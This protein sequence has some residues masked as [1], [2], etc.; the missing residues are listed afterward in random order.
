[1]HTV[2]VREGAAAAAAGWDEEAAG[3]VSARGETSGNAAASS[4]PGSA[5]RRWSS[6]LSGPKRPGCAASSFASSSPATSAIHAQRPADAISLAVAARGRPPVHTR[7]GEAQRAASGRQHRN[8]CSYLRQT[9]AR[10][11][12]AAGK[13]GSMRFRLMRTGG[14]R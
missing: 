9:T 1:M 4:R 8:S 7:H 2:T 12:Q 3:V 5:T 10:A 11:T 13:D 6:A 14:D